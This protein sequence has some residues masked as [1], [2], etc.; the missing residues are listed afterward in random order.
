M[1]R[2]RRTVTR[3]GKTIGFASAAHVARAAR[4]PEPSRR[5]TT[6]ERTRRPKR[7][8]PSVV[9]VRNAETRRRGMKVARRRAANQ[10]HDKCIG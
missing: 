10:R 9:D 7:Y 4:G 8:V 6:N 1:T 5:D 2:C 3:P